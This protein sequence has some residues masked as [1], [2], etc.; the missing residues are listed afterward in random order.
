M[1][2]NKL[3]IFFIGTSFIILVGGAGHMPSDMVIF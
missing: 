1:T 3:N 2:V